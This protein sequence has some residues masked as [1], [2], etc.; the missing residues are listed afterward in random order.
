[1]KNKLDFFINGKW[2]LSDSGEK[3]EVINPANE[4]LIGHVTAGTKQDVDMAVSAALDAFET[5]QYS[6]KNDR[7][8]LLN[9]VISEYENRVISSSSTSERK[10]TVDYGDLVHLGDHNEED[11]LERFISIH[12]LRNILGKSVG[13]SSFSKHDCVKLFR[14]LRG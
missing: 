7:I 5:F 9:N 3:I 10:C 11:K 4:T 12:G 2:I 1:M 8:E 6:S 14:H 13:I